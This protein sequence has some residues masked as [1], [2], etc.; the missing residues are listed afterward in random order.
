MSPS[1][2]YEKYEKWVS[3]L[4]GQ[5]TQRDAVD[6]CGVD[7]STVVHHL[8]GRQ[9]GRVGRACCLGAAL[10]VRGSRR[11]RLRWPW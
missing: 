3:V 11:S 9:A 6:G 1:E 4:T 5:A 7:R 8:P 10:R 2:K